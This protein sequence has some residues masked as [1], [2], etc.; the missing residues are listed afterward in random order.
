MN[1]IVFSFIS[2]DNPITRILLRLLLLPVVAGI[3][4]EIIKFAG[5]HDNWFTNLIS[6]PGMWLQYITTNEPDDSQ[7]EVAIAA[8]KAVIPEDRNEDKW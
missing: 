1:I 7:I 8:L 5:R 3:S 2:W 6:K 4:Y